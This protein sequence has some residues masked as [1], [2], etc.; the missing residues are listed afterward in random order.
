MLKNIGISTKVF[1][2]ILAII[3][4]MVVIGIF[5]I[6]RLVS[7]ANVADELGQQHMPAVSF[8]AKMRNCVDTF[9]RS[10]LQ[11]Y[12]KNSA[13]DF[14][15]YHER[16][17]KMQD[18]LKAAKESY[19]KLHL[20]EQ[21]KK[22]LAEFETAWSTYLSTTQKVIDLLKAGSVDE[23]QMLTRGDGKKFYDQSNKALGDMQVTSQK[24]A[25]EALLDVH[26]TTSS[27]R[28]WIII[29]SIVGLLIGLLLS[30]AT[31]KAMRAPL[32]RLANDAE[33]IATGDLGVEV[34]VDS[35][36]EVG[37]LSRSFEK[38]VNSLRELIGRLADSSAE[39]LKSSGEM[40]ANSEQVASG[41]E[42]V[43]LQAMTVATASEEMS[44]TSGDIAQNCMLAAESAKRANNAADHGA[45]VVENSILVMKRIAD[46]VKSSALTVGELGQKSDQIGAIVGTIEDIADQTNLLALNAAIEAARAGEQ[47]RGFAVVA[48]EVRALAERTTRATKE[49]SEMI[50]VIQ[51]NTQTAVAAMEDGVA[52]VQNGTAEAARSGEALRNI[53]DEINAVNLQ[54][55]QIAT[56]AEEQTATTSEI[57]GNIHQ[58]TDVV[59]VTAEKARSS[60]NSAQHLSRLS[61]ELQRVVGQFK[62]SESGNLISW[63]SSYSVGVSKMDQEHK[64]LIDIINRLYSSMR[65]G[66]GKDGI[67]MV[68]DELIDYTKTHFAHEEQLM[69]D[70]RFEGYDDQKRAHEGLISQV[71]EVQ[72][73]FRTGTALS[74]EV[75]SFLKN[76]LVN[77]I[78]GQDKKYGP[79][80]NK[81][82]IR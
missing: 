45:T 12:L 15:R 46:R 74:Q 22:T 35:Q 64:R 51:Q 57:S 78:Q 37:D 56:A 1:G 40:Q 5:S 72:N 3:L 20:S 81:K 62:L 65:E 47:G 7:V 6:T 8:V 76:W 25:D 23:A 42:E 30:V 9:R 19:G 55:Q 26:A 28:N 2:T 67:G 43:A 77:H 14:K 13:D 48:D 18:E 68:L 79:A 32:R 34:H 69:L 60:Y 29:L 53:Q 16:M 4:I 27:A 24:L 21:E 41:A 80:M 49:I 70:A 17:G 59:N 58:I 52:E 36:D 82:G 39:V 11:F 66:R 54:V 33:Q 31:I 63:S 75:M 50:K 44:A 38:M 71:L 61:D 10:E 73:K